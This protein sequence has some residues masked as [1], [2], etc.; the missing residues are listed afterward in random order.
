MFLSLEIH[1]D[2]AKFPFRFVCCLLY[3]YNP[4]SYT[5]P[6][7]YKRQAIN[8]ANFTLFLLAYILGNTSPKSKI[9]KVTKTTSTINF[10]TGIVMVENSLSS[11]NEKRITIATVSY[12][13]LDVYKRQIQHSGISS[14]IFAT[15][16]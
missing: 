11:E 7:V 9:K 6:D 2:C 3:C 4:V 5:H 13:H 1:T 10:K 15:L 14:F 16:S 8:P 12:T